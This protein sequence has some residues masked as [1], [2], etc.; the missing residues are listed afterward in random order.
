VLIPS[1]RVGQTTGVG[2]EPSVSFLNTDAPM[3]IQFVDD[4]GVE[5]SH[6]QAYRNYKRTHPKRQ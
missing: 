2:P 6:D 1:R 5:I 4:N 3:D